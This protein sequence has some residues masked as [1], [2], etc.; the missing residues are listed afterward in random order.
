M[1]MKKDTLKGSQKLV[2]LDSVKI[3]HLRTQNAGNTHHLITSIPPPPPLGK[4]A[5]TIE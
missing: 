3:P 4:K 2:K 5:F 1:K